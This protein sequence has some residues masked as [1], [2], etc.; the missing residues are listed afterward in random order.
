MD[1]SL[2]G[3]GTEMS[4]Q[5][6]IEG[7]V[8]DFTPIKQFRQTYELPETFGVNQFEPKDFTGLGSIENAGAELNILRAALLEAIRAPRPLSAWMTEVTDLATLFRS[9]LL[10]INPVVHLKEIEIDFATAGMHDMLQAL[11]YDLIRARASHQAPPPFDAI[12]ANWL[13]SSIKLSQTVHLYPYAEREVWE[14]NLLTHVYGRFGLQV[15]T[16]DGVVYA[17][18]PALACPAMG[19]TATL[20]GDIAAA[21]YQAS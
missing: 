1:Y 14:I 4:M 6:V 9:K 3:T 16:R 8:R 17:Y 20:L 18:D 21:I 19:Y 11:I 2:R 15:R 13:Y 7:A 5:F 12:Y 10:Q